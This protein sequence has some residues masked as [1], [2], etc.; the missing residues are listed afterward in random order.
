MWGC[1]AKVNIHESKKRKLGPKTIDAVFIGYAQNSNAY[2]FLV[3]KSNI[4]DISNNFI[5]EA[6]DASF[7]KDF[8]SFKTRISKFL[9]YEPSSRSIELKLETETELR[10]SK[11]N[12]IKKNWRRILYI[13]CRG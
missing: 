8:F 3:I 12:K 5:L 10:R 7:F 1:L 6:R 13:S 11:K 2:R 4:S 9:E